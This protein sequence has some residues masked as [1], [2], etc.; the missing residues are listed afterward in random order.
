[1]PDKTPA[2]C[3]L[4]E[5]NKVMP[6]VDKKNIVANTAVTRDK[7]L[8]EPAAPNKPPEDPPPN[9]APISAPLPC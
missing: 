2:F 7:K 9:A 3:D 8:A 4:V 1:V 5:L 6:K